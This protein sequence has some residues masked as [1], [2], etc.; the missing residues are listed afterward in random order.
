MKIYGILIIY[1]KSLN[2]SC[3][4]MKLRNEQIYLIVCDNSTVKNENARI[5]EADHVA[6]FNMNGNQGL[7]KAYNRAVN[8]ITEVLKPEDEDLVCFF[9]DDTQIP[10][11]YFQRLKDHDGKILLPVVK[12]SKGIM[13]PVILKDRIVKRLQS[14]EQALNFPRKSLSGINSG[15]AVRMEIFKNYRYN[16]EMFL[17]Y[18]DHMFI[19]D[20]R[21]LKIFPQVVDVEMEQHFSAVEDDKEAA[22]KRFDIQKKDLRIFY[23]GS[24]IQYWYVVVKKHIKLAVK[25]R[26][27]TM[28][29]H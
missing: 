24:K 3:A 1:N 27:L 5:A 2:E 26:D 21:K 25:Y 10:E 6:Y 29:F 15:M 4:Y 22:G 13:S 18:I 16:E 12:D 14:K 8:Y 17:D 19:M 23:G 7:S 28:I 9:D 20:M 11:E